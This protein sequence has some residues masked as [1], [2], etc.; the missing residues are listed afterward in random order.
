MRLESDLKKSAKTL[1]TTRDSLDHYKTESEKTSAQLA[2]LKSKHESDVA[3]ARKHA[4]GL[5][6]DKSDLQSTIDQLKVELTR[7][8]RRLPKN[9][10]P[11]TPGDGNATG[12]EGFITPAGMEAGTE[13][14]PFST[15]ISTNRRKYDTS[16]MMLPV[17]AFAAEFDVDSP[18]DSPLRRS[19]LVPNHPYKEMEALQQRLAHAQRQINTLK[20]SLNREKMLRIKFEQA[21]SGTSSANGEEGEDLQDLQGVEEVAGEEIEASESISSRGKLRRGGT[22]FRVGALGSR[23]SARRG[24]RGRSGITLIQRLGMAAVSPG[25]HYGATPTSDEESGSREPSPPPPIPPIPITFRNADEEADNFFAPRSPSPPAA[26]GTASNRTSVVSVEG[27]DPVFA[28]ILKRVPSISSNHISGSPLRQSLL[29]RHGSARQSSRGYLSSGGTGRRSRGGVPFKEARPPSF[30]GNNLSALAAELGLP[31]SPNVRENESSSTVLGAEDSIREEDEEMRAWRK[32]VVGD[33]EEDEFLDGV[34]QDGEDVEDVEEVEMR[35]FGC[36]TD[37]VIEKPMKVE[38]EMQ[39]EPVTFEPLTSLPSASAT[40][41]KPHSEDVRRTTITQAD[42]PASI[43][44]SYSHSSSDNTI[45]RSFLSRPLSSISTTSTQDDHDEEYDEGEETETGADTT[46]ETETETD[47]Y[48]ARASTAMVTPSGISSSAF[49]ESRESFHSVMTVSDYEFPGDSESDSESARVMRRGAMSGEASGRSSMASFHMDNGD[50]ALLPTYEDIGVGVSFE[51]ETVVK[52][53]EV[54]REV[55]VEVPVEVVREVRVEVPVEVV[56]EVEVPVEVPVEVIKEVEVVKEVQV[57]YP[58]EVIRQVEVVKEVPVEVIK[59]VQVLVEVVKEIEKEVRVPVEVVKEVVKEV[60]VE[61]IREVKVEVPVPVTVQKDV[62]VEVV[63]EVEVVKEVMVEVPVTK[64][65]EVIKEVRVEVPF[66]VPVEIVKEVT[67]EVIKEVPVEVEVVREV[68]KEVIREVPVEIVHEVEKE[69]IKEVEVVKEV[70]VEVIKEIPVEVVKEVPVEVIKEIPVEVIKEIQVEVIKEIPVEIV[71]EVKVP[72]EIPKP[73]V[74]EMEVQ[75]DIVADDGLSLNFEQS[76]LMDIPRDRLSS[77]LSAAHGPVFIPPG[78]LPN[79]TSS[80]PGLFR[81]GST[82]H[83]QQFQFVA[84]PLPAGVPTTSDAAPSRT[85]RLSTS[86]R[87]Q[88]FESGISIGNTS[89]NVGAAARPVLLNS[90]DKSKPP[91]MVL[92]PPPKAPPPT[93]SMLPPQFIPDRRGASSSSG[94]A[95][96]PRPS[97]PPPPELIQ[98]ATTPTFGSVLNVPGVSKNLGAFGSIRSTGGTMSPAI[99]SANLRQLPSTSSIKSNGPF[100]TVGSV[101]VERRQFSTT[102]LALSERSPRSSVSSSEHGHNVGLRRN[103][104]TSAAGTTTHAGLHGRGVA[105]APSTPNRTMMTDVSGRGGSHQG[106][107]TDPAIIHAITQTMIGEFMYK[108]T[109]KA[110]GKGH[111]ERRHRRFFWIHPYTKTLYWSSSDPGSSNVNESSAKSGM[112]T[113][114]L[115]YHWG[116]D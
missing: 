76:T 55:K 51:P 24:G 115:C 19:L 110:I 61:V 60:P 106:G 33:Y 54:V 73:E 17:D 69:V 58:V 42:I 43:S 21:A 64:E 83:S 37:L 34:E 94:G 27:M 32:E 72:I 5:A 14:D 101:T 100:G 6:R 52:E 47:Y 1:N 105:D 104:S 93:N 20:G 75:T 78:G 29:S 85:S 28:N 82:G 40:K 57:E 89:V 87:R 95:P 108:Y 97:S 68:E 53:I 23:G 41:S 31:T 103:V 67:V 3:Q 9:G 80:S 39:T 11:L 65:V 112:W 102:S 96:P 22:P 62:P 25:S 84:S 44:A 109:R 74:K 79:G 13:V 91:M 48:D 46:D 81:V 50:Q 86:D 45:T 8:N 7:A 12:T 35:E 26:E 92:P 59:E 114:L 113:F 49:S 63:R 16:G 4:A 98:R 36:Q 99:A 56:R 38:V 116:V 70:P 71:K 90:M 107:G 30:V 77:I 111:G 15:G 10:S 2:D 18:E 66:E 88:S